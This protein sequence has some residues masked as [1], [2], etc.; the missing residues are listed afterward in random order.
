MSLILMVWSDTQISAVHQGVACD[1]KKPQFMSTHLSVKC[2]C[3]ANNWSDIYHSLCWRPPAFL[4]LSTKQAKTS[5]YHNLCTLPC[6]NCHSFLLVEKLKKVEH[7]R[8]C[9]TYLSLW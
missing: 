6:V 1:G 8:I 2:K 4:L 5:L 9:V 3:W 7:N